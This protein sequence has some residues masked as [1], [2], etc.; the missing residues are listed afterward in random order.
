[1]AVE[2]SRRSVL[3]TAALAGVGAGLGL[4]RRALAA[5]Q[6]LASDRHV[7]AIVIGSGFGGAVT[8]LRL[9]QAGI[10]TL[11]LERGRRWPRSPFAP[12]FSNEQVPDGRA[13]WFQ[14]KAHFPSLLVEDTPIVPEAGVMDVSVSEGME[15]YRA[16]AVGGGSIVYT[17]ASVLPPRRYFERL[18]PRGV[19][20]ARIASIYAPR[21]QRM[22]GFSFLP[23]DLYDSPTWDHSRTWDAQARTAGFAPYPVRSIFNWDVC[24]DELAGRSRPS[25]TIGETNFGN[26]NGAKHDLTQNYIPAAEATGQVTVVPLTEVLAIGHDSDRRYVVE[27]RQID[28]YGTVLAR[29]TY[30]TDRLFLCAGSMGTSELLVRA[31]DTGA[32]PHLREDIGTGWGTNGDSLGFRTKD[33]T[34]PVQASPCASAIHVTDLGVPTTLESWFV[35][36]PIV[37]TALVNLGMALDTTH[38]GT[39][40][41][42]RTTD[43]VTVGW[44]LS[45]NE[46]LTAVHRRIN[47]RIATANNVMTGIPGLR[48]DIVSNFTAHP[49]G[50]ACLG[51]S[52]DLYG[53]V[54]GY[55]GLYVNDGALIPGNNGG[56]NPSVMIASIAERNIEHIL[57]KDFPGA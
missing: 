5:E 19:D 36:H 42:D 12:V 50:G 14:T 9:G 32:L 49:L 33:V 55:K 44:D 57:A 46:E 51:H 40:R 17:G 8:A 13:F 24:R 47:D 52:T 53:R 41:Y 2:L 7:P 16:A 10:R 30:I 25:A 27:T 28:P 29:R 43:K 31:R 54:H 11:V 23:P 3:Q 18:W 21:A 26:A 37:V 22:L 34:G 48:P 20:Y 38:R 4:T 1:M 15:V 56:A 39:F 45:W 6:A 35:P